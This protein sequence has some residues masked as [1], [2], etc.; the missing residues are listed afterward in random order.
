MYPTPRI[1][2][3]T[4]GPQLAPQVVHMHFDRVA[5]HLV[6]P[7]VHTFLEL[8][9]RQHAAGIE[10]QLLE[11]R[12]LSRRQIHRLTVARHHSRRRI[13][14]HL[15]DLQDRRRLALGPPHERSQ[16]GRELIEVG[17][18]DHVVVRPAIQARNPILDG[19]SGG[20]DQ[21]RDLVAASA[22]AS[23]EFETSQARQ[24]RGRGRPR[25]TARRGS[26]PARRAHPAPSPPR[27]PR[28]FSPA[29]RASPSS[30]SSSTISTR[31]SLLRQAAT[32]SM[33]HGP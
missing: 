4:C 19:I 28:C 31:M 29:A 32:L 27:N 24:A 16:P 23:Q 17:R 6:A 1:V 20:E 12:E 30:G 14:H 15:P 22:L 25:Q 10:H 26:R 7:P 13:E 33:V 21:H 2:F 11:Q 9:A 18:F 5:L 8:F 3:T